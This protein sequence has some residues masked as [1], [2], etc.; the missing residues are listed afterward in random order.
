M[1]IQSD[2]GSGVV[3]HCTVGACPEL[4]RVKPIAAVL[5]AAAELRQTNG[6]ATA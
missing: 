1:P 6:N 5:T 4:R 3:C 2:T